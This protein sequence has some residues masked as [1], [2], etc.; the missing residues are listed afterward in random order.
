MDD[1]RH[2]SMPSIKA[3]SMYGTT[4]DTI[5]LENCTKPQVLESLKSHWLKDRALSLFL[6]FLDKTTPPHERDEIQSKLDEW[7]L[8][9]S[10][11]EYVKSVMYSRPLLGRDIIKLDEI[12]LE[13]LV[14]NLVAEL[15]DNQEKIRLIRNAWDGV[16]ND[17][18]GTEKLAYE[19]QLIVID[20]FYRLVSSTRS[21]I[22]TVK[23]DCLRVLSNISGHREIIDYF[24]DPF[25][26][27]SEVVPDIKPQ[28]AIL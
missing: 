4:E 18:S 23:F 27:L 5:Y 1:G 12:Q 17:L 24:I 22:S 7:F 9:G 16:A 25:L 20:A 13:S 26:E 3:Y 2:V 6:I 8:D 28:I 19:I 10:V 21:E 11:A 14:G 15:Y